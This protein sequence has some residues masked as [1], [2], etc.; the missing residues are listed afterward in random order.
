MAGR[1]VRR[2]EAGVTNSTVLVALAVVF[3]TAL[4][5][6]IMLG[7]IIW[8]QRAEQ[9][10]LW[11]QLTLAEQQQAALRAELAR[12]TQ[13]R[14][15][16]Q[17]TAPI[18]WHTCLSCRSPLEIV[19]CPHCHAPYHQARPGP[20]GTTLHCWEAVLHSGRCWHCRRDLAAFGER[21]NEE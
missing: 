20:Q 2:E 21:R 7:V 18:T 1:A 13:E 9:T 10:L 8:R 14:E 19:Q 4:L 3:V 12:A 16:L 17:L 11:T 5:T 15:S 6:M